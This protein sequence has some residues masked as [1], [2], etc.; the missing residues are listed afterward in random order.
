MGIDPAHNFFINLLFKKLQS[1][2]MVKDD[3]RNPDKN[4][5]VL[6]L[7]RLTLFCAAQFNVNRF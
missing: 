3:L 7:R 4:L 5:I 2:D 6:K 1:T